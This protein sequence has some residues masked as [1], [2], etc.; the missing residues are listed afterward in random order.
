VARKAPAR[1]TNQFEA[2][3][4]PEDLSPANRIASEIVTERSDLLPSIEHIMNAGLDDETAA[5]ALELFRT[6]LT[7]PGDPHR[8]P[9]VAISAATGKPSS[10]E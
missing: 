1:A 3:A 6:S 8:D 10:G 4:A 5:N 2:S 9:R 7:A